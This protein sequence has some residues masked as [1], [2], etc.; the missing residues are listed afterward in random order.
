M[1]SDFT[2]DS[3]VSFVAPER[4]RC[5][6][7]RKKRKRVRKVRKM[8]AKCAKGVGGGRACEVT[9]CEVAVPERRCDEHLLGTTAAPRCLAI[10]QTP[11]PRH[12]IQ[13]VCG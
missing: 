1:H 11:S 4:G 3:P 6:N 8:C 10:Q 2:R 13:C 12:L 9:Q 5:A 7:V